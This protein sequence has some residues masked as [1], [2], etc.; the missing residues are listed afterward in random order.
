MEARE[1][2]LPHGPGQWKIVKPATAII[3]DNAHRE[4]PAI[5]RARDLVLAHGWNSTSFQIVNPGIKRWFSTAGD[6][7]VGYVCAGHVRVVA[8]APVCE[9]ERLPRVAAEFENETAAGKYHV[10]YFA[11]ERRLESIYSHSPDHAKFLLGAQP[12]W[13]PRMWPEVVRANGSLRAQLNRARNKGVTVAEWP[14]AKAE[15][16]SE[17]ARCLHD[18]LASKGLPPLHFIVEPETLSRLE[19]R[20]IFVAQHHSGAVGFVV[21][22]PVP[23]RNGWLFEQFPHR[24]GAPNGTV[25]L[26]IDSAMRAI[27]ESGAEYATLGLSPLSIRADVEP[28]NNPVW[29]RIMLAWLR[30]HGQRFYNFDGLDAFKSKLRPERWE[31]VFAVSNEPRVSF[32]TLYAIASAF[33]GGRPAML[34]FGGLSRAAITEV[35]NIK[36]FV[37]R[38]FT[39]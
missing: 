14:I 12:V 4:N 16:N 17:L 5:S 18:W 34:V 33:S 37:R 26:M 38:A 1:D 29:L 2:G 6:A 27:G 13:D 20:R 28:F 21:L 8:G 23:R 30:K 24:P 11:A 9:K 32:R 36:R 7:V 39:T 31:P 22:S 15:N 10:C 35:R 19:N 25:E 3:G